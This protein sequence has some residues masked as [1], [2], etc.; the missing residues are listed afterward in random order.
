MQETQTIIIENIDHRAILPIVLAV[1]FG[2]FLIYNIYRM[3]ALQKRTAKLAKTEGMIREGHAK[4][5]DNRE[6]LFVEDGKLLDANFM[7]DE[8]DANDQALANI[9]PETVKKR[10]KKAEI[11]EQKRAEAEAKARAREEKRQADKEAK[12]A[13]KLSPEQLQRKRIKESRLCDAAYETCVQAA[14]AEMDKCN[15]SLSNIEKTYSK[16]FAY[17]D[18]KY[19]NPEK[20]KRRI[21]EQKEAD[22]KAKEK[23]YKAARA[24]AKKASA[25]ADVSLFSE[26]KGEL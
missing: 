5:V 20:K 7:L 26:K 3:I 25:N 14:T 2:T 11:R 4:L 19:G 21:N 13:K 23:R 12:A 18:K 1:I 9:D 6:D 15:A 8:I 17:L 10:M 16:E 24:K 22:K